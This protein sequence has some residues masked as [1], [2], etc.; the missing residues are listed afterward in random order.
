MGRVPSG[1]VNKRLS[2]ENAA[3]A[4]GAAACAGGWGTKPLRCARLRG[5]SDR[6]GGCGG[7]KRSGRELLTSLIL[8]FE[9]YER[10]AAAV[11]PTAKERAEKGYGARAGQLFAALVPSLRL[12]RPLIRFKSTRA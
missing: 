10:V 5:R 7:E 1:G 11:Q 12:D 8:A 3:M 6:L 4:N 9:V 2:M